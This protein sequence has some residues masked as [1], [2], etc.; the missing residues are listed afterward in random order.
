VVALPLALP[1][2]VASGVGIGVGTGVATV[3]VTERRTDNVAGVSSEAV[4]DGC[5]VAVGASRSERECV[6][7][8]PALAVCE[9]DTCAVAV[10]GRDGL[11]EG[12]VDGDTDRDSVA[13]WLRDAVLGNDDVRL[14]ERDQL[15]DGGT[16]RVRGAVTE[17]EAVGVGGGV[18]VAVGAGVTVCVAVHGANVVVAG[19]GCGVPGIT[20]SNIAPL[21]LLHRVVRCDVPLITM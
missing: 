15:C 12:V 16:D 9:K 4:V 17:D 14:D 18:R 1:P 6:R 20:V 8:A 10:S 13:A 21:R 19:A 5:M 7:D 11:P 2:R 3:A